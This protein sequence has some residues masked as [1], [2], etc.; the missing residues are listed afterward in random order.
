MEKKLWI[1]GVQQPPGREW[2]WAKTYEKALEL[3]E[4][5]YFDEMSIT[6]KLNGLKDGS[7]VVKWME[8][9]FRNGWS[10]LPTKMDSHSD[11]PYDRGQFNF[12]FMELA[13][14]RKNATSTS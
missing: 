6:R 13:V 7:D 3:L 12:R 14:L 5:N 11:D 10:E 8:D 2:M 4:N 9:K 1:D